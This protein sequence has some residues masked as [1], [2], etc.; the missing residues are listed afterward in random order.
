MEPGT[1]DWRVGENGRRSASRSMI[2]LGQDDTWSDAILIA[3]DAIAREGFPGA[4]GRLRRVM[5][6]GKP[7]APAAD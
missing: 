4:P 1:G 7:R 6:S 3:L 5:P 2:R